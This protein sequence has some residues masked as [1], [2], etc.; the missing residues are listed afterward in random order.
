[1]AARAIWKG[2][3]KVGTSKVGVKLFSAVTDRTVHFRLLHK[4]DHQPVRQELVS[5][6]SGEAVEQTDTRKAFQ[7][8]R[9]RFIVIEDEELESILP[10]ES[11]DI[12]IDRFVD[13]KAIDPRWYERAY[14]LA[15]DESS[16]A[17]FALAAA[18]ERK[19]KEAIV[20]WVMRKKDYL[21]SL[22]AEDGYLMLIVLRYA[23]E[24][25]SAEAVQPPAGRA[26]DKREIAMGE[27]LIEALAGT[28]D[29]TE[30]KDHYRARV[31]ELVE[32]KSK[33]KKPK[34]ATFRPRKTSE[35]ALTG[36]LQ[37]SLAGLKK[38]SGGR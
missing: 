7:V 1:M 9:D 35:D 4:T 21:G 17:Y 26:L 33:G 25:I 37:A 15:P 32:A 3:I 24:I 30:Y 11:R 22:R 34:V 38:A 29:P 18:M 36:A 13:Q 5:S 2:V 12:E 23:D 14:W 27:Q 16:A 28:F 6:D 10:K 8:R 20:R 31:M 19:G